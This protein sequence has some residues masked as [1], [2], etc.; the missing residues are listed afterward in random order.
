MFCEIRH[1]LLISHYVEIMT[2]FT[3]EVAK[4]LISRN[5]FSAIAFYTPFPYYCVSTIQWDIEFLPCAHFVHDFCVISTSEEKWAFQMGQPIQ[6]LLQVSR[7]WLH[8]PAYL[9]IA[10]AIDDGTFVWLDVASQRGSKV[11][12]G[13]V[14]GDGLTPHCRTRVGTYSASFALKVEAEEA[15][16]ESFFICWYPIIQSRSQKYLDWNVFQIFVQIPTRQTNQT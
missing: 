16:S 4:E 14:E 9:A 3:K 5:F 10:G 15:G 1:C 13:V 8:S 12:R 7:L 11:G 6:I 2:I